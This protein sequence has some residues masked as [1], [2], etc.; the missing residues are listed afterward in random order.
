MKATVDSRDTTLINFLYI[1]QNARKYIWLLNPLP[2]RE[3][4]RSLKVCIYEQGSEVEGTKKLIGQAGE[5]IFIFVY[6]NVG[7]N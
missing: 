5:M 2:W 7:E 4:T 3:R 1:S 6:G